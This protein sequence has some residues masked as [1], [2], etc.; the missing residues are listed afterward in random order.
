MC[1]VN[2]ILIALAIK[3]SIKVQGKFVSDVM[4]DWNKLKVV[5]FKFDNNL[6]WVSFDE[7][8]WVSSVEKLW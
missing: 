4:R 1:Y 2:K 3:F 7:R 6:W 5:S 8:W